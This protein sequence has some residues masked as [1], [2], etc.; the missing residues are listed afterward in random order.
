[1]KTKSELFYKIRDK[2][3]FW[4]FSKDISY[5][6]VS[7]SIII[8]Y[9]LK[10]GDFEDIKTAID[11]YGKKIVQKIWHNKLKHDQRFIKT[12]LLIARVFFNMNV[13]SNYFENQK[14]PRFEKLVK[15]SN[16]IKN[17]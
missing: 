10:Y 9:I 6:D 13:E 4:S 14:N 11:L 1:M 2:G 16:I 12:N 8:E 15:E 3:I 7:D 5:S 17:K